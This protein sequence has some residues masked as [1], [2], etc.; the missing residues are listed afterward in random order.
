MSNSLNTPS[1]KPCTFP[2]DPQDGSL[3]E[4]LLNVSSLRE[5]LAQQSG[6]TLKS[7]L[8]CTRRPRDRLA[9]S[10]CARLLKMF[11]LSANSNTGRNRPVGKPCLGFPDNSSAGSWPRTRSASPR[12]GRASIA[13]FGQGTLLESLELQFF[14]AALSQTAVVAAIGCTGTSHLQPQILPL[15][16]NSPGLSPLLSLDQNIRRGT[17][18]YLRQVMPLVRRSS[19][20]FRGVV[21]GFVARTKD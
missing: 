5:E 7:L 21:V 8:D 9:F 12:D 1:S 6:N 4:L 14:S 13:W 2:R 11:S 18:I 15:I 17:A 20:G 3:T 16:V 10:S 19:R